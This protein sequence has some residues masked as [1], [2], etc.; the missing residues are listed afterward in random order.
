MRNLKKFLALVLA[1]MMVFSLMVTANAAADYTDRNTVSDEYQE[2]VDVTDALGIFR[3]R[4]GNTF[5]P[6][7]AVRR[8]EFATVLY[9]LAT[10]DV[11]D[12][13][14]DDWRGIVS[15]ADI[16]ADNWAA[17]YVA[18]AYSA[19]LMQGDGTNFH[20]TLNINGYDAA[21]TLLRLLGYGKKGE[22]TGSYQ[23]NVAIDAARIGLTDTVQTR[24]L[25][26]NATRQII[27]ALAYDALSCNMVYY[28]PAGGTYQNDGRPQGAS[29]GS[30]IFSMEIVRVGD[31]IGATTLSDG[32]ALEAW[33]HVEPD[34]FGRPEAE[35]VVLVK[36]EVI[37]VG[38]PY[39]ISTYNGTFTKDNQEAI[40]RVSVNIGKPLAIYYNSDITY[41]TVAETANIISTRTTPSETEITVNSSNL[42]YQPEGS[43]TTVGIPGLEVEVYILAGGGYRIVA[44]EAYAARV[45][46]ALDKNGE[47]K[48]W[49][50]EGGDYSTTPHELTFT[51]PT[52][53]ST[54]YYTAAYNALAACKKD[55][56]VAVYVKPDWN[57]KTDAK[58][59][60][61]E[62][63][64]METE[65]VTIRRI[66]DNTQKILS[67][68]E[69]TDS[70]TYKLSNEA[71]VRRAGVDANAISGQPVNGTTGRAME[72]GAATLYMLNGSVL[73]VD[74]Y[75]TAAS[76]NSGYA[77]L[78]DSK[79]NNDSYWVSEG[80]ELRYYYVRLL[81][82]NGQTTEV[83]AAMPAA[84]DEDSEP[85]YGTDPKNHLGKLVYYVINSNG[86]YTLT[87]IDGFNAGTGK[88]LSITNS[89][90]EG[91]VPTAS[92]TYTVAFD[93]ATVFIVV[94]TNSTGNYM[95][96]HETYNIYNVPDF[97][98]YVSG[99]VTAAAP[100]N[101]DGTNGEAVAADGDIAR[102]VLLKNP[103]ASSNL[104]GIYFI[105]RNQDGDTLVKELVNAATG[106]Y[107]EYYELQA[108]VNGELTKVRVKANVYSAL[109]TA[110]LNTYL[111]QN[112]HVDNRNRIDEYA[113]LTGDDVVCTFTK[114]SDVKNDHIKLTCVDEDEVEYE[115]D[116]LVAGTTAFVYTDDGTITAIA[117]SNIENEKYEGYAIRDK[118]KGVLTALFLTER[119]TP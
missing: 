11:H 107:T 63:A 27:A 76:L 78:Y 32:N 43:N 3:G 45:T 83:T 26:G 41:N 31:Q 24:N 90:S 114:A 86:S 60:V 6:Q 64:V 113:P 89:K 53:G 17:P 93:S 91:Q 20:P 56:I 97:K 112:P 14:L 84:P 85:P 109:E 9:R 52:V 23:L 67:T 117:L 33:F 105:A 35:Y 96:T 19:G 48:I 115:E 42:Y 51:K 69:T 108:V 119:P 59:A 77:Y 1:M 88:E 74:Q 37:Y 7:S 101:A 61:L 29:L 2:A 80:G 68:I 94:T 30:V 39:P 12:E 25:N 62:V 34:P 28:D 16:P 4:D 72:V 70:K 82:T 65:S 55:A 92:S 50:Y 36:N 15:F 44:R 95:V 5:Q 98:D 13:H 102:V 18:Y 40:E 100:L 8:D 46:S 21:L 54:D 38:R 104:D 87:P 79:E 111:T 75:A 58:D 106:A 22:Y 71:M 103:G 10:G 81:L 118:D 110:E 57:T 99:Y 116:Y 47:I 73:F 49:V 66:N